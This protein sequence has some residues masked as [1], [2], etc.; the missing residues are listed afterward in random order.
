MPVRAPEQGEG[1][2]QV[3]PWAWRGRVPLRRVDEPARIEGAQLKAKKDGVLRQACLVGR[4]PDVGWGITRNV[5]RIR[6]DRDGYH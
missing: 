3:Q 5:G 2:G 1:L 4:H 6:A